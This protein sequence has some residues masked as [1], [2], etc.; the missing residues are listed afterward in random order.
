MGRGALT[1][2]QVIGGSSTFVPCSSSLASYQSAEAVIQNV[3]DFCKETGLAASGSVELMNQGAA[4][5]PSMV[6]TK[7]VV[8]RPIPSTATLDEIDDLDAFVDLVEVGWARSMSGLWVALTS[9]L[10]RFSWSGVDLVFLS[11]SRECS[12]RRLTQ[13][14]LSHFQYFESHLASGGCVD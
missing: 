3:K 2:L 9:G 11:R 14:S 5:E 7:L 13:K 1:D 4:L 12:H 10:S 6:G 8:V